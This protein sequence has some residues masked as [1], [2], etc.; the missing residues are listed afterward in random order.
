MTPSNP[1]YR[2]ILMPA[3]EVVASG[4]SLRE[5]QAWVQTYNQIMQ[6]PARQAVIAEEEA[7]KKAA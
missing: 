3:L 6:C 1:M 5:A 7:G 4:L 2:V